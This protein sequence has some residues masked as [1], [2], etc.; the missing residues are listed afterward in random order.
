MEFN[1]NLVA[2]VLEFDLPKGDLEEY[3]KVM[4]KVGKMFVGWQK[5]GLIKQYHSWADNCGYI[6]TFVLFES[7]DKF[8]ELW[9][10]PEYHRTFSIGTSV[11]NNPRMKLLR[12]AAAPE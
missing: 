5:D 8:A 4:A 11:V 2:M 7:I 10:H 9:K 1:P 6:F 12:P 3:D